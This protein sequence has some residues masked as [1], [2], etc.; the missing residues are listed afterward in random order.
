MKKILIP[1]LVLAML[2]MSA[3]ALA[4]G[5]EV[6]GLSVNTAKLPVYAADDP[7]PAGLGLSAQAVEA[8]L[9]VLVLQVKQNLQLQVAVMPKTVK[10][11]KV[12]LSVDNEEIA[13]VKGNAVIGRASGE[14]VLTIASEANPDVKVQFTVLVYQP[15]TRI[16]VTAAAKSVAVGESMALTPAFAPEEATLKA[17]TWSSANEAIAVVDENGNVSGVKKGDVR[18]TAAAKD[19]S[20]IK[21]SINVKVT[22]NAEE[23]TL[24]N[25]EVT[26]D[27]GRNTVLKATVLP[28]NTDDKKVIWTS[29]DE[30]IAT[31]N[32]QGRVTGVALGDCEIIC[33]SVTN[34]EVQ[35]RAAIHVQQPVTKVTFG[36]APMVYAGESAQLTWSIEPANASNPAVSFKSGNDKIL[37]VDE[38]GVVTGVKAGKT[39]VDVVT[40]DGSKRKARL[41]VKVG[42][43]VTGVSM[44]RHTAYIDVNT[45]SAA[46]AV[47]EPG[48]ATNQM[49]TWKSDDPSIADVS[50]ASKQGNKV[51]IKGIREGETVVRGTTEDGGFETSILVKVGDYS[52]ALK[53]TNA[54][55]GGKGQ[56]YVTV[57]N[58]SD[59][60]PITNIKLQ[61]EM[62]LWGGEPAIGV[63]SNDGSNIL[64]A[65][66]SKRLEPGQKTPEDKWKIKDLEKEIPYMG[67]V[68]RIVEYQIDN[69]WIKVIPKNKR[70]KYEYFTWK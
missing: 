54:E 38:N 44:K 59:D 33:A 2:F 11:K 70:P 6:N 43:H 15:V 17:V 63:N 13:K 28:K 1:L 7:A 12:T 36:E 29:S 53:I 10:N 34:G 37:T 47:V 8:N 42:Q 39:F 24:D 41:N 30:S 5:E 64:E 23:I 62:L 55:I 14:T 40:Q 18:I 67:F 20:G 32:A 4:E 69:D 58:V 65:T 22:Q 21:A 57:R 49:M 3:F 51:N 60:L 56:I 46:S 48:N 25:T 61:L 35:A 68:V 31:V 50:L 26:V 27:T 52:H 19:G 9:P 66:Y 16:T 45:S